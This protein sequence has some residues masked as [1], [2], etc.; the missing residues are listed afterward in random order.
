MKYLLTKYKRNNMHHTFIVQGDTTIAT[1]NNHDKILKQKHL[2]MRDTY[3]DWIPL[4]TINL[5]YSKTP[6]Y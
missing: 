4:T 5:I 1:I 2:T 6:I 3:T